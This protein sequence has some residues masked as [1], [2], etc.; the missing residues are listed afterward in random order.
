MD[1]AALA[2]I[3]D[4]TLNA[5]TPPQQC[6][7]D[8]WM[9]RTCPGKAKRARSI[10]AVA[11][12]SLPLDDKLARAAALFAEAGLPLLVRITPFSRPPGLDEALAER[13]FVRFDDSI[14]MAGP[15][16]LPLARAPSAP[17]PA[18]AQ[19]QERPA[20]AFAQAVGALRGTPPAER[21]VH[22]QRL[23]A[24]PVP[25]RG[26]VIVREGEVLACGQVA[27]EGPYAGLYDVATA[28]HARG[29]GLATALCEHMLTLE[30][31][32]GAT[33]AYLQVSADNTVARRVYRRLGLVDAYGYHYR[34]APTSG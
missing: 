7:I 18:G 29:N 20:A 5:S 1:E 6:W 27:R 31:K 22:A 11:A 28:E 17:L 30:A 3:E 14:V 16:P 2:C 26:F 9:V 10:N 34:Q 24:S 25:Y 4:A 15:L 19:V 8:G 33:A 12:G 13:G 32:A 23:A 21:R